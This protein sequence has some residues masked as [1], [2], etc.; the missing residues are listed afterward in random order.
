M[1]TTLNSVFEISGVSL[2]QHSSVSGRLCLE[3]D[4]DVLFVLDDN[5]C[6]RRHSNKL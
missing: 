3:Q 5:Y 2:I 6:L 4:R 1:T